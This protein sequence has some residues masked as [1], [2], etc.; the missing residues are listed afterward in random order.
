V[1]GVGIIEPER[2]RALKVIDREGISV[3]KAAGG[4]V[5]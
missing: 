1:L 5:Q 4:V 2:E 3:W